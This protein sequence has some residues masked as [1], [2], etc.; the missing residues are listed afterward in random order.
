MRQIFFI[1]IFILI[2]CTGTLGQIN[3]GLKA[4]ANTSSIIVSKSGNLFHD[5]S[6][7]NRISYHLG[8]YVSGSISNQMYWQLEVLFANK[9]Y[10]HTTAGQS[11]FVGIDYLNWPLLL[12]YRPGNKIQFEA[13]PEFSYMVSGNDLLSKFDFAIDFGMNMNIYKKLNGGIRYSYG[14]PFRM[15]IDQTGNDGYE[16]VYQNSA[17]FIYL[18]FSLI[19]E[20]L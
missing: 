3:A 1:V 13:G 5:E 8:S 14:L 6:F 19:N 20:H 4:G 2:S 9:G 10:K 12:V 18:G 11:E 17:L 15:N 7:V 16:P